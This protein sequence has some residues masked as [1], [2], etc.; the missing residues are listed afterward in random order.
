MCVFLLPADCGQIVEACA[1]HLA[2]PLG[3]VDTGL[4]EPM[5]F[6]PEA[7]RNTRLQPPFL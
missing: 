1:A 7:S 6:A 4:A 3:L 2:V 5:R